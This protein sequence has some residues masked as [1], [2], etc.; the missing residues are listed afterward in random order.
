MSNIERLKLTEVTINRFREQLQKLKDEARYNWKD[1][2][3]NEEIKELRKLLTKADFEKRIIL[4]NLY[5]IAIKTIEKE[6]YNIIKKYL[7]R[8][9]G[10]KTLQKIEDEFNQIIE[11]LIDNKIR[12][13]HDYYTNV[14]SN[15]K[16]VKRFSFYCREI[17]LDTDY[18]VTDEGIKCCYNMEEITEVENVEEEAERLTHIYYDT[19]KKIEEIEK[20]MKQLH[21]EFSNNFKRNTYTDNV[22]KMTHALYYNSPYID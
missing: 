6:F 2:K 19:Y 15:L 16:E 22:S 20:Q 14:Y 18:Y 13:R 10:E 7:N 3:L 9:I 12:I 5:S 1:K 17:E 4:N 21:D 8:N 11:P